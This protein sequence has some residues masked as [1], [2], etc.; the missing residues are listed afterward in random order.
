MADLTFEHIIP[1][2]IYDNEGHPFHGKNKLFLYAMGMLYN[3]PDIVAQNFQTVD[4]YINFIIANVE[5]AK[6]RYSQI[7]NEEAENYIR[8]NLN[9]F[10]KKL[11]K[12]EAVVNL[13]TN[14]TNK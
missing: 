14:P 5:Q 9:R 2:E 8:A 10:L 7:L 12:V 11:T 4:E 6:A 13:S 3:D 1:D